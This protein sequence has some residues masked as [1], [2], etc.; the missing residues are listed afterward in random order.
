M[1]I[2]YLYMVKM[3]VENLIREEKNGESYTTSMDMIPFDIRRLKHN[4]TKL[5]YD[6]DRK[7]LDLKF[8][9]SVK[10]K[11]LM[12]RYL[13]EQSAVEDSTCGI[14]LLVES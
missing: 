2:K 8:S 11:E 5:C 4:K 10:R 3:I 1:N 9:V 6:Y 14:T 12:D 7:N 13:E